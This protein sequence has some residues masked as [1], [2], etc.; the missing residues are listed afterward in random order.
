MDVQA[1]EPAAGRPM[2]PVAR[3]RPQAGSGTA[4]SQQPGQAWQAAP[5]TPV[6]AV[7]LAAAAKPPSW[8][9][10]NGGGGGASVP[11]RRAARRRRRCPPGA[12]ATRRWSAAPPAPGMRPASSARPADRAR[13]TRSTL[14][15][16]GWPG[17]SNSSTHRWRRTVYLEQQRARHAEGWATEEMSYEAI[18]QQWLFEEGPLRARMSWALL[19]I[20]VI[21][22]IAPDIRPHA[23]SSYL[24][25]LNQHAFGN[26]RT[27]LEAVTLH[28]AMG[29]YLNLLES[30]KANPAQGTHPNENYAREVLQLFSIGLVQLQTDGSPQLDDQGRTLPT[31]DEAV[32]KGFAR[33]FS[34]WSYGTLDNRVERSFHDHDDNV[35]A[36]MGPRRCKPWS[37]FHDAGS[38]TLLDGRVPAGQTASRT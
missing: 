29:Y 13:W 25:L 20:F 4:F 33:T 17:C 19:Q 3:A 31:Y 14:Q 35:E 12:P 34:G 36:L 21:S 28:P 32:V 11:S 24:D 10:I 26:H 15:R 38:K 23:M 22:N 6:A 30:E 16:S 7:T 8:R 27:L 9:L 1:L 18:W 5:T 2:Q 37:M